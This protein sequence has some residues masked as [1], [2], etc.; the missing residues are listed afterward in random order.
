MA[1]VRTQI[2]RLKKDLR[3]LEKHEKN[4]IDNDQTDMIKNILLKKQWI[5]ESIENLQIT[6]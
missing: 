3:K 2:E 1:I 5:T 6:A 4:L